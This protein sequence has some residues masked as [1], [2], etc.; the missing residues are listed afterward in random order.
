LPARHEGFALEGHV[1]VHQKAWPEAVA[2]YR[3]SLGLT[4]GDAA[5]WQMH[6]AL[7][8]AQREPEADRFA[9]DWLKSHVNDARFAFYLGDVATQAGDWPAA[10]LRYRAVLRM[11]PGNGWAHNNLAWALNQQSK[12]EARAIIDAG[13]RLLPDA[14]SLHHTASWV[15]ARSGDEAAALTAAERA[16]QLAPGNPQFLLRAAEL[17]IAQGQKN[18]A[19]VWL[20]RAA[21]HAAADSKL[22]AAIERL[23][24]RL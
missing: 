16:V 21:V 18:A 6:R 9:E 20:D 7:R 23:R 24:Q 3:R 4:G 22:A 2:S 10:E 14:A 5:A 17:S 8:L 13:L 15:Y 12:A 1:H 11:Q 19:R